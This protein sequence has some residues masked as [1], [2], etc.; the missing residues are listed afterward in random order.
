[1]KKKM[2]ET[3]FFVV[4]LTINSLDAVAGKKRFG[5]WPE[6]MASSGRIAPQSCRR[7]IFQ[8]HMYIHTY[9]G[10]DGSQYLINLSAIGKLS[11]F[12]KKNSRCKPK[13]CYGRLMGNML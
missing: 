8:K 10:T 5:S 2:V 7:N 13:I 1:M 9:I 12:Q 11:V 4:L 3:N 6:R